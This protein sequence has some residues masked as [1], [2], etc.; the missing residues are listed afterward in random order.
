MPKNKNN[1]NSINLLSD[2]GPL[3]DQVYKKLRIKTNTS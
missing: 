1:R 2:R 3:E